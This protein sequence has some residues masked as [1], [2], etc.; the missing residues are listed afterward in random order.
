MSFNVIDTSKGGASFD[1]IRHGLCDDRMGMSKQA[2][3][4]FS[5][6]VEVFMAVDIV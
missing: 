6:E 5:T 4:T 3:S 2:G 1:G